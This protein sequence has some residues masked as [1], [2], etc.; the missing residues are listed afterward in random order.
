MLNPS[1][2]LGEGDTVALAAGDERRG[3][4]AR[5]R[6]RPRPRR[7]RDA[8]VARRARVAAARRVARCARRL[9]RRPRLRA[10]GGRDA[11]GLEARGAVARRHARRRRA[12]RAR[13]GSASATPRLDALQAQ[14][15]AQSPT[16]ALASA[17][18]AQARAIV[19]ATVGRRC[20]R[21]VGLDR[22][23]RAPA[24]L[25]RTGRSANYASPNFSTV[26]NDVVAGARGRAT[27]STSP[28]ACS[29]RVEGAQAQ[30]RAGGG[31]PREHAP[32]ARHRPR[33]RV[34]QPARDRHRA[35]RAGA[36][37]RAAAPRARLRHARAT[38]S[39]PPRAST[40]R[41]SR[42]CSTPR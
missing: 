9:R 7:C 24:H 11:A 18:L 21:S 19:A 26:Q 2:S 37:D 25:G 23:R 29:A 36:L 1:D 31:R 14:A 8:R 20:C 15:L 42:R 39:A 13:G 34:L 41:S 6:P 12:E 35:R 16:L 10:P 27:S 33:D 38:T 4:A 40:S 28:A 30:R 22:A 5:A 17:R 3:D 32:A